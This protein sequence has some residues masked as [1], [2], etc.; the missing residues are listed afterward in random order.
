[1]KSQKSSTDNKYPTIPLSLWIS[2]YLF[3]DYRIVKRIARHFRYEIESDTS[4]YTHVRLYFVHIFSFVTVS[5]F[6]GIR[7]LFHPFYKSYHFVIFMSNI[8]TFTYSFYFLY[9]ELKQ[10]FINTKQTWNFYRVIHPA[11]INVPYWLWLVDIRPS[12]SRSL[13]LYFIYLYI[14]IHTLTISIKIRFS[15]IIF[16]K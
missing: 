12:I 13:S 4:V 10:F 8:C 16:C 1:M 5:I 3:I 6:F 15:W 11:I 9:F 14:H 2:N 7:I